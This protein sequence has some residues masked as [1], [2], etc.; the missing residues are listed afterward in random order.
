MALLSRHGSDTSGYQSTGSAAFIPTLW[1]GKMIENFYEETIFADI[2][3]TDYEGEIKDVG[4]SV[5]INGIPRITIRD[6]AFGDPTPAAGTVPGALQYEK[7]TAPKT[8]LEINKAKYFAF[9][10]N[11]IEEYQSKPDLMNTF[12]KGAGEDMKIA[13]DADVLANVYGAAGAGN[14]GAT[15]GPNSNID[16]GSDAVP[17]VITKDNVIDFLVNSVSTIMDERNVPDSDR[18]IAL[19]SNVTNKIKTSELKDASLSGDSTSPLRNGLIG[20]IDRLKIYRTNQLTK[21]GTVNAHQVV[22]GHKVA[23]TFASQMAKVEDLMNPHDFGKLVRGL[24][25][26]GYKVVKPEALFHARIRVA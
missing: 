14:S 11:D 1:A 26:Y 8:L 13:I 9:E 17:L 18:W 21:T 10:C 25:V 5:V 15:A 16:L 24:N 12:S 4:D 20:M 7:P 6:Y 22:F 19:P 3:N 23:L 2:S